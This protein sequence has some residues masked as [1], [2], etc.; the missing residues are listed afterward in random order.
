MRGLADVAA[1]GLLVAGAG[2]AAVGAGSGSAKAHQEA[3][4]ARLRQV[5]LAAIQYSDDKRF[6]PHVRGRKER[7]GGVETADTPRVFRALAWFG[8]LPDPADRIC[9]GSG[10]RAPDPLPG[11]SERDGPSPFRD[12]RWEPP[13]AEARDLSY[14]WRRAYTGSN[15]RSTTALAA[16]RAVRAPGAARSPLPEA[17]LAGNHDGAVQV[18]MLDATVET[19]DLAREPDRAARLVQPRPAGEDLAIVDPLAPRRPPL[20]PSGAP[21]PGLLLA[22]LGLVTFLGLAAGRP[23]EPG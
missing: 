16:D 7:D 4:R 20:L 3:C 18:V 12:G 22:A 10:D 15:E 6:L 14:G 5:G 1:T 2:L 8:Y 13:L 9:A 21:A 23:D 19:I 11:P 17:P